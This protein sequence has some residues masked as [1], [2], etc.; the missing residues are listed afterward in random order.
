MPRRPAG[1]PSARPAGRGAAAILAALLVLGGCGAGRDADVPAPPAPG[2]RRT[3]ASSLPRAE[4]ALAP[5]LRLAASVPA[6]ALAPPAAPE[7][8]TGD[9]A[10]PLPFTASLAFAAVAGFA[11]AVGGAGIGAIAGLGLG[12]IYGFGH[13]VVK[14]VAAFRGEDVHARAAGAVAAS[15]DA[16]RIEACIAAALVARGG[17]AVLPAGVVAPPAPELEV[18]VQ[19]VAPG[20]EWRWTSATRSYFDWASEDGAAMRAE[21]ETAL[22]AILGEILAQ[23]QLPAGEGSGARLT[24]W[25]RG[26]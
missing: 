8:F 16:T 5:P 1:M 18:T 25:E 9:E 26:R 7:R 20:P 19:R 12:D 10:L 23:L 2:L 14:A 15:F 11:G 21:I 13:G 3:D 22:G 17:G 4:G 24:F 6:T